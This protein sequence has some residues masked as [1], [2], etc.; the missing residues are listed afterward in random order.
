MNDEAL[1]YPI[2]R[3]AP[4]DSY[5]K[6]E[7]DECIRR[8][9]SLPSKVEALIKN[10]STRQFDTAYRPGGW[11]ARQVIHHLADS[12]MNAYIRFK[13]T[14]TEETPVIKAYNEKLWAETPEIKHDPRVSLELLKALHAKWALLLKSLET[15]DFQREYLHPETKKYNRLDR[16]AALYAWHGEHH[17]GHLNI[18]A[19]QTH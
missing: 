3:F 8:I 17:L 15:S 9:E 16:V 2:G 13:W 6:Q 11:T 1:K 4:R 19:E 5:S 14:L 18:I 12:H 10:F 7:L